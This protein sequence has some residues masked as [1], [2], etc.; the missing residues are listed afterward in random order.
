MSETKEYLKITKSHCML[1]SSKKHHSLLGSRILMA[2]GFIY[3]N[4]WFSTSPHKFDLPWLIAKKIA[5]GDYVGDSY[6]ETKFGAN[7]PIEGFWANVWNIA[8]IFIIYL[9]PL[10]EVTYRSDQLTDFRTWWIKQRGLTQRCAFFG[11]CLYCCPF[12]GSNSPKTQ[13]WVAL[14]GVFEPNVWKIQTF[15]FFETA[16]S[17]ATKFAQC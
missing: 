9:Y 1:Y 12:K 6:P 3:G 10:W 15:I 14:I 11:F 16:A 8:K 13:F 17:I 5:T 2:T 4:H 7:L